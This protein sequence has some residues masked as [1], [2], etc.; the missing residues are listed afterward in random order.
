[1]KGRIQMF[2]KEKLG[3]LKGQKKNGR[4]KTGKAPK[5]GRKERNH[6]LLVP[7][8]RLKGCILL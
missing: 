5:K 3:D 4:R 6:S 1:M 8:R 2:D 7:T